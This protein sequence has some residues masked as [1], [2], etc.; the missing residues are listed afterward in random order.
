[1]PRI[2]HR[3]RALSNGGVKII[4][5]TG[6]AGA[7]KTRIAN[8]LAYSL[9]EK[10]T[11]AVCLGLDAFFILSSKGR[12]EWIAEGASI[13]PE[14]LARRQDQINWWDFAKAQAAIDGLKAGLPLRLRGIYNRGDKGELTGSLDIEPDSEKGLLVLFEGVAVAHL[15]H[16]DDLIFVHAP[17][18]VRLE[19]IRERDA[20]RRNDP[21]AVMARWQLTQR[22]ELNYFAEHWARIR[23]FVD[24][25]SV[26]ARELEALDQESALVDYQL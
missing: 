23:S 3:I 2:S 5:I 14:E 20:S 12:K 19:R 9:T 4:G 15:E 25:S 26:E 13:S 8:A 24:N 1:M 18:A 10:G 7:G 11:P 6:Q 16:F 21:A 22:F 17:P